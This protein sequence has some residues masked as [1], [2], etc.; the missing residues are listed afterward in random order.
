MVFKQYSGAFTYHQAL[1]PPVLL[2]DVGLPRYWATVRA[3]VSSQDL[4]ASTASKNLRYIEALYVF[5][6]DQISR[7]ALKFPDSLKLTRI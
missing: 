6:D 2:D 3:A 4:A 5:A 1:E 7:L